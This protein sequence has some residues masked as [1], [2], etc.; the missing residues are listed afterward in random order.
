M[1]A[2]DEN[3]A[4]V[5]MDDT[6]ANA[7]R[8]RPCS[9]ILVHGTWGR[10]IFPKMSDLKRRHLFRGAK[11][12]FDNDSPF[13]ARLNM[14]LKS[15]SL[16]GPI[17]AFLWSG[18]NSVHARDCAAKELSTQLRNELDGDPDA[19]AVIIAHSHGGNVALRAL[20]YLGS[21]ANRIR[22][23]TLATP[24]LRV[25]PQESTQLSIPTY[26]LILCSIGG[27]LI[28]TDYYLGLTRAKTPILQ[29]LAVIGFVA[30]L[31]GSFFI[32]RWLI[33]VLT[34]PDAARAT[35]E[36]A[37]YDIKG[38]AGSRMLVIRGVDDEAE[39]SLAAGLIGS[40]FS[41]LFVVGLAPLLFLIVAFL[42]PLADL[43]GWIFR[44]VA[45][46][47]ES[48]SSSGA[49]DHVLNKFIMILGPCALIFFILMGAFKSFFGRDLLIGALS[50]DIAVDSVPDTV[51]RV[52]AIT[53]P[54][55]E[56]PSTLEALLRLFRMRHGIYNHP[57]CAHEITRWLRAT[58]P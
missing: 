44:R 15:A 9:I 55:V 39:L 37:Y 18:A 32:T 4:V 20:Q 25:F 56:R 19:T 5:A 6:A 57:A 48:L 30:A 17:R 38:A 46:G 43:L 49:L 58:P 10:G 16:G 14:A 51:N 53:L 50:C 36:K 8:V 40:L 45:S 26:V 24:F 35:A 23:V 29:W 7:A 54:P 27:I 47:R 2:S 13:Q 42:P 31:F 33:A 22:V 34:D 1:P 3:R 11:R 21:M 52:E 28:F 12:W 41:Y